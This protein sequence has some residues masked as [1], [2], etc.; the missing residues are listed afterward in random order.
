MPE[1]HTVRSYDD[2]LSDLAQK[3]AEMGGLAEQQVAESVAAL[4]SHD[5]AAAQR[6]ITADQRIDKLQRQ[7]EDTA[8]S[9]IARRQPVG[10][11]LRE[12][13][14]AIHIANDLERVGDLAKNTAKRV[15]AVES[16]FTVQ[17][18]VA[19]VEHIAEL[20]LAQP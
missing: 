12:I 11:D 9:M 14:A 1:Q 20:S 6:I 18:L 4:S 10:Q 16:N 3:I 19:S 17:R 15:F 8:V 2:E 5:G 7:I 13:M